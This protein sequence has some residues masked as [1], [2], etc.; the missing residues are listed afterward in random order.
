VFYLFETGNVCK[1]TDPPPHDLGP[2]PTVNNS[3]AL[4]Y[5]VEEASNMV[6][7]SAAVAYLDK[8]ANY[9]SKHWMQLSRWANWLRVN[10]L[11]PVSQN[12]TDD[13]SGSYAHSCLLA[14]KALIGIGAY[15]KM[16]NMAGHADSAAKYRAIL[17]TATAGVIRRGYDFQNRHFKKANDQPGTWSQKYN[18]VWD[19]AL[20]LN[21]FADSIYDNEMRVYLANLNMYGVPLLSSET[22]NK[23]DWQLWT[24][25]ITNRKS[26]FIAL[27]RAEWQW[28]ND[29][30]NLC[31]GITDWHGTLTMN[32][33]KFG[34]RGVVGG[35]FMK[36]LSDRCLRMTDIKK[37]KPTASIAAQKMPSIV[38][39]GPSVKISGIRGPA[40]M[41]IADVSGRTVKQF[42]LHP[43]AGEQQIDL[44]DLP[45]GF[46][47]LSVRSAQEAPG[48]TR[49]CIMQ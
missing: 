20:G 6:I 27:M 16:A 12:S 7:M 35:Y 29:N 31:C 1:V 38:R 18:L 44:A 24:A 26:D 17:D 34:G 3:C 5:W 49:L 14:I 13:F 46:Y 11:D 4:G 22:Y 45:N 48:L 9:V 33:N 8:N 36:I 21:V 40:G 39:M 15:V 10:G 25:A 37:P 30:G 42:A 2:W 47:T 28:I 43:T 32:E 41:T 23:S 19:R